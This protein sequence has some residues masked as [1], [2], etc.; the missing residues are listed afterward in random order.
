VSDRLR[1]RRQFFEAALGATGAVALARS[2]RAVT[3]VQPPR[4]LIIDSHQHFDD[5][6]DYVRSLVDTYRS[7]HA[8]ACVLTPMAGFDV[9]RRAA[10]DHPDVVIPYGQINVDAPESLAEIEKFAAAGFKGIKMHSPRHNW[11]D[12]QYF[13]LYARIQDLQLLALFH[14]G[15]AFHVDTPQY[16]SMARMRPAYLDT[17]ARAFPNL[18]IQG[19]HLGNPWYEE[20]AEATR[21]SPR[22]FFDV[23]GS[24]L[25]KKE[26]NLAVFK[27]YL[28]WSGPGA[29]SSPQAVYA[30]EKLVFGTDEP[31]EQVDNML[32][33][34]EAMLDACDVPESSRRK[35]FGETIA[36]ILRLKLKV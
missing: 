36:R 11:D 8:M 21:W 35:I 22:L 2:A 25:I 5:R 15:I 28:W 27:E 17:I 32:R 18:Y 1:S 33:R 20:A 30:F 34:Y 29:H 6:P 16:T 12:P 4:R 19:A 3:P 26:K 31:P 23:T 24:T 10:A 7:R 9:I 13:P 14:T